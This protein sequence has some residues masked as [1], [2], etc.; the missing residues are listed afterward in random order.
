MLGEL[1]SVE[2]SGTSHVFVS[3]PQEEPKQEWQIESHWR[4][5]VGSERLPQDTFKLLVNNLKISER[6]EGKLAPISQADSL[7]IFLKKTVPAYDR[8]MFDLDFSLKGLEQLAQLS[9]SKLQTKEDFYEQLASMLY[10]KEGKVNYS[11]ALKLDLPSNHIL[12]ELADSPLKLLKDPVPYFS[13]ALQNLSAQD[14]FSN[15]TGNFNVSIGEEANNTVKLQ[16]VSDSSWKYSPGLYDA[17]LS[18]LDAVNRE[19][20]SLP[21][22]GQ[23]KALQELITNRIDEVKGLVPHFQDFGTIKHKLNSSLAVNKR[24]LVG[25][26]SLQD[27]ELVC[28]LYGVRVK[29]EATNKEGA[30][31]A[32]S[33]IELLKYRQ[34][35]DD[36][37]GYYN[38]AYKVANILKSEDEPLLYPLSQATLDKIVS[39]LNQIS[40]PSAD[41]S[42]LAITIAYRDGETKVGEMSASEFKA[43]L[44]T[45][46]NE[47]LKEVAPSLLPKEQPKEEQQQINK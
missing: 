47:I 1:V 37:V 9:N 27:L 4:I 31:A 43:L 5:D 16:V 26:I 25:A 34:L 35:L 33:M 19:A 18:L 6:I 7:Q 44:S 12:S 24:S 28:D 36:M 11:F 10:K 17:L 38:R 45:L 32:N 46:W 30:V 2:K 13:F 14:N 22:E 23:D 8:Q 20:A 39:F 3:L 29:G 42:D 40:T 15:S 41:K 21:F